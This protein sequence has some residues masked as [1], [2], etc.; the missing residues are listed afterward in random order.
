MELKGVQIRGISPDG[1][2]FSLE[3]PL[4]LTLR[5]DR[6]VPCDGLTAS[7]PLQEEGTAFSWLRM[8]L[9]GRM[10]FEGLVDRQSLERSPEGSLLRL[11]CRSRAA[12]LVDNEARPAAYNGLD[13]RQLLREYG[14]GFPS[15]L[16]A[17]RVGLFQVAKGIS[18]WQAIDRFCLAAYRKHPYL[19]RYG[20]LGLDPFTG[21]TK[22][23]SGRGEAG[24]RRLT[25]Q[26]RNDVLYSRLH[27]RTAI[28]EKGALYGL[29][30]DNP[31]GVSRGIRR[32]RY[33][34]PG[35]LGDIRQEAGELLAES[36][37]ESF[38]AEAV[39]PGLA[40]LEIGDLA[41]L[42]GERLQDPL[43][44]SGLVWRL[45]AGGASTRVILQSAPL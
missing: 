24:W 23:I 37:R 29:A 42:E 27:L 11:E 16:P 19:D 38:R 45:S 18:C 41:L 8:D 5:A 12:L 6:Q 25:I 17:G 35:V 3:A 21:R 26:Q 44:V 20:V 13:C 40:D 34:N 15:R 28:G 4:E 36:N 30:V 10:L 31:L 32:E 33:L 43:Y 9:G 39:L 14:L 22:T 1:Q 7:F 2:A